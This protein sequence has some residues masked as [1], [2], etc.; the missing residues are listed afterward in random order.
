MHQEIIQSPVSFLN[1]LGD[2]HDVE[3][4]QIDFDFLKD[5]CLLKTPDLLANLEGL[6][7]YP[8]EIAA[9]L[10][11]RRVSNTVLQG[12]GRTNG[13]IFECSATSDADRYSMICHLS[14]NHRVKF[15]FGSMTLTLPGDIMP[16][17]LASACKYPKAFRNLKIHT[18]PGAVI[19]LLLLA[20]LRQRKS[21]GPVLELHSLDA[22]PSAI[23]R[24]PNP[25]ASESGCGN[26]SS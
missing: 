19:D 9:I 17:I 2:L 4:V 3:I 22:P 13:R 16:D 12:E 21:S 23:P 20:D 8:G 15:S 1:E 10:E 24:R 6:A 11:F 7:Q 26:G 25:L 5:R 14:P 18:I